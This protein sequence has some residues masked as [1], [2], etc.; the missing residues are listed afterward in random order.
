[1]NYIVVFR[2]GGSL[3][4]LI[5]RYRDERSIAYRE[6]MLIR[7]EDDVIKGMLRYFQPDNGDM[8]IRE[9][10][11]DAA[12]YREDEEAI[13]EQLRRLLDEEDNIP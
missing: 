10:L 3:I 4:S 1:M 11:L 7:N 5:F 8:I 6:D 9:T 12:A 2:R 13:T